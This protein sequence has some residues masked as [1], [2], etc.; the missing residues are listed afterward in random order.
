VGVLAS[1]VTTFSR[2]YGMANLDYGI[3]ITP[4]TVF[5]TG[6]VSKQFTAAV[7]VLLAREG[8]FT[9]DDDIRTYFSEIP[10]Y[11]T[12]ITIRN[13]L[14]HTS[15]IRDYLELMSMKGA[16]DEATYSEE[17]VVDLLSRQKALNFPPGS[18]FLYSN[19][20]YVLLSRLVERT[21]GHTLRE[22]ADRLLFAPL[23]MRRTHFHDD[24]REIVPERA[25]GYGV[26]VT[27]TFAIDQTTLDIVGDGGV[28]TSVEELSRWMSNFGTLEVGGEEWLSEMEKAGVLVSGD[29]I[30]YALGLRHGVQRG[31][32]YV[33]HGGAFVGYRAATLRYPAQELA[34]M[35]LCNFARTDPMAMAL[36][37]G[38]IL[39]EDSMGP[40]ETI[41]GERDTSPSTQEPTPNLGPQDEEAFLGEYYSDELD[42]VLR[43]SRGEDGLEVDVNGGWTLP[44]VFEGNDRFRAQYLTLA[45]QRGP[46]GVT[47]LEAGSGRAGGLVFNRR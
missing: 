4:S 8:Y 14:H 6:S 37:V 32:P 5:R 25:T 19:S 26:G 29:T 36:T 24:H 1:G 40:G 16:G 45:F 3:A 41:A 2:G 28:F 12:P 47:A 35:V 22:Q 13:L 7:V 38:G 23:E 18:E 11:G 10:D 9:L 17:D 30:G 34:I 46:Q 27:P 21:T 43:I 42:S 20:G 44:L 39:L 31:V 15:G 33:G